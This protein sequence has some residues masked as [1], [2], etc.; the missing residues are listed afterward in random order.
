MKKLILL[1]STSFLLFSCGASSWTYTAAWNWVN[2]HYKGTAQQ[3]VNKRKFKW[4]FSETSENQKAEAFKVIKSFKVIT[5]K[6][7]GECTIDK[8][9]KRE[10]E[11][12]LKP[13]ELN[14]NDTFYIKGNEITIHHYQSD[15]IIKLSYSYEKIYNKN[16]CKRYFKEQ[17]TP[18]EVDPNNQLKGYIE[19]DNIF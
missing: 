4:N 14:K 6:L 16:G 17:I 15:Q 9:E 7:E 19:Y 1:C 12:P 13:D 8:F 11:V 3:S 10:Y 2:D 18:F 5:D